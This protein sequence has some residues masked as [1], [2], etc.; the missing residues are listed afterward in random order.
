MRRFVPAWG[1]AG[2]DQVIVHR[3]GCR[4]GSETLA[5]R[6]QLLYL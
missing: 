1:K 2:A 3:D 4:P 5:E 6:L